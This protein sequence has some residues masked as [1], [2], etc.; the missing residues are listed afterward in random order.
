MKTNQKFILFILI[1][2][3]FLVLLVIFDYIFFKNE[4]PY[5]ILLPWFLT[6]TLNIFIF[7]RFKKDESQTNS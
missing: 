2:V 3:N 7:L 5:K 4:T 1:I 6:V